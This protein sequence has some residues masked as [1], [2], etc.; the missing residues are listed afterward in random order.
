MSQLGLRQQ[1]SGT[2]IGSGVALL[3]HARSYFALMFKEMENA[4]FVI[5]GVDIVDLRRSL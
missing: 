1:I 3:S 5:K 4:L 2:S